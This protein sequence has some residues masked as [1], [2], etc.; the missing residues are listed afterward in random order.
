M[1]EAAIE[2]VAART[3]GYSAAELE[4]VVKA[5]CLRAFQEGGRRMQPP[6]LEAARAT[7]TPLAESRAEEIGAIRAWAR[8]RAQRANG[9]AVA[10][11]AGAGR[12]RL[13]E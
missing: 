8:T 13:S 2:A 3:D 12:R 1:P 5:A 9:P 6:D 10:A 4:Q 11:D 7:V